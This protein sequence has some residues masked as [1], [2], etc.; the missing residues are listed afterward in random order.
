MSIDLVAAALWI[1][2]EPRRKLV[3]IALCERA[4]LQT[5]MC[6]PGR[7]EIAA[8]SSITERWVTNHMKA[9]EDDGYM[10]TVHKSSGRAGDTSRRKLNVGRIL[11]EGE[12]RREQLQMARYKPED[13]TS[14][15]FA[16]QGTL[17]T[18]PGDVSA[19]PGDVDAQPGDV[20]TLVTV[21]KEPSDQNLHGTTRDVRDLLGAELNV[22]DWITTKGHLPPTP[23]KGSQ[24]LYEEI[25]KRLCGEGVLTKRMLKKPGELTATS[26]AAR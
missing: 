14:P 12:D 9:L 5:G 8:R 11:K 19:K 26:A 16:N 4:D 15:S 18:E 1:D 7:K 22:Y 2:M 23:S 25:F 10:A 21:N 6:W 24:E 20:A 13:E 3:L 17:T